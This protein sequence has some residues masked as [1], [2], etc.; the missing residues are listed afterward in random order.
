[1]WNL[2]RAQVR[3]Q[4]VQEQSDVVQLLCC[5]VS[6]AYRSSFGTWCTFFVFLHLMYPKFL[7][8]QGNGP[9]SAAAKKRDN[10]RLPEVVGIYFVVVFGA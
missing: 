3:A 7:R 4:L 9:G 6:S 10:G 8:E 2:A 5:F 1:L